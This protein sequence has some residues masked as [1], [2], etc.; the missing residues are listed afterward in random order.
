MTE[1]FKSMALGIFGLFMGMLAVFVLFFVIAYPAFGFPLAIYL[2]GHELAFI[3]GAVW[4]IA[5]L[6]KLGS[7]LREKG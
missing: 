6:V 3:F 2:V 1:F 7:E 5:M 4:L